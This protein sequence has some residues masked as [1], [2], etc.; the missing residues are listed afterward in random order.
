[1]EEFVETRSEGIAKAEEDLAEMQEALDHAK[2]V[3]DAADSADRAIREA[4]ERG[5]SLGKTA[6]IVVGAL[7]LIAVVGVLV[8]RRG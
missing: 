2:H 5:R 4:A 8:R 3:V 7:V 6:L 1:L